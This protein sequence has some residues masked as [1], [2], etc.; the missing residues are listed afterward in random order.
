MPLIGN[1]IKAAIELKE[2]FNASEDPIKDQEGVL[3]NLLKKASKTAFGIYYGFDQILKSEDVEEEFKSKISYFDYNSMYNAWWCQTI[4][5]LPDITWP[6]KMPYFAL[7]SGTTGKKSKR[8]PVSEQMLDAIRGTAIDQITAMN[9]FDLSAEFFE[10][11]FLMLGSSTRL[12]KVGEH[13]EGEISG[14]SASNLPDWFEGYYRPGKEISSIDDWN[15]RIQKIAEE[16]PNWDIGALSGIPAWIELMLKKI[17]QVQK[18]KNIHEI[19]PNLQIYTSGGV[20]FE[21]YRKS[22]NKLLAHPIQIVE[23]YLASEGFLAFQNSPTT[24]SLKLAL[25]HGVYFEFIPFVADYILEDGS[26]KQNAPSFKINEV[27]EDTEYILVISTMSGA[28]R[29]MIGDTIKFTDREKAEFLITGR[30]KH[31]LNVVGEQLSILKINEVVQALDVDH[32]IGMKEYTLG[33]IKDAEGKYYHQWYIGCDNKMDENE[34]SSFLDRKLQESNKAYR[35]SRKNVLVGV[36]VT[37]IPNEIF[38]EW[39]EKTKKKGGQVKMQRVMNEMEL[40]EFADFVKKR[41]NILD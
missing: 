11:E 12:Q 28:W 18:L 14:I 7:S 37:L 25:N 13:M 20:A 30:T 27:K 2:K 16:A 34:S 40:K 39:N 32:N 35:V 17:I 4:K 24:S 6:G 33:A 8:I 38:Y 9:N 19:W 23:T 10:K 5:D 29:Y 3:Q 36:K 15:L 22:F 21:P 31:F 1:L 41:I 26:I